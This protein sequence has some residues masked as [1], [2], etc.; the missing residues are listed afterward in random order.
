M[1]KDIIA[2]IE[3][4]SSIRSFTPEDIPEPT[5]TRLIEAARRAPSAGNIQP[6]Q[7]IV[8]KNPDLRKTIATYAYDQ[9]FIRGAPVIIVVCAEPQRSGER[10]GKR[11]SD[12]YCLQD[13]AAAIENLLLAA[14]GY[15]LGSCWVG[16]FDE[17]GVR[18][19]LQLDEE[20]RPVAIIAIGHPAED[21]GPDPLRNI[22]DVVR[23]IH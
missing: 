17:N 22:N 15:G 23:I 4:R 7:F 5:I 16:A 9:D 13:T 10:Y 18:N 12:L 3:E 19:I 20:K 14:T 2:A 1:T 6:W 8:V 11:G 21:P